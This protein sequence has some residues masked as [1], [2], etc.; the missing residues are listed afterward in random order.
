MPVHSV[1]QEIK[2]ILSGAVPNSTSALRGPFPVRLGFAIFPRAPLPADVLAHGAA[3][4]KK[5]GMAHAL[6]GPGI[7]RA[8]IRLRRDAT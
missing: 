8:E 1:R 6:E 7:I 5:E 4:L 3:L 2:G